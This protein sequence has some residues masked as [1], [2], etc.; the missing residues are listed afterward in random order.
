LPALHSNH[1]LIE[2]SIYTPRAGYEPRE[3][4]WKGFD[5][6]K[7]CVHPRQP[8]FKGDRSVFMLPPHFS[9]CH[10]NGEISDLLTRK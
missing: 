10:A 3:P 1:Q 6:F 2:P 7:D 4:A 5:S 9:C 8:T